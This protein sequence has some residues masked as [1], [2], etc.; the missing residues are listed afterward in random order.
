MEPKVILE[1]PLNIS[2][3]NLVDLS[4]IGSPE[5]FRLVEC[6]ALLSNQDPVLRIVQFDNFK[7]SN[8]PPAAYAAISYIWQG[9]R[10]ESLS[11]TI[12]VEGA[13][14][15][16]PI[17]INIIQQA[18]IACKRR[19]LDYIWLDRLCIMQTDSN[20]KA[21]QIQRMFDIYKTGLPLVL[22]GGL[23]KLV[24]LDEETDWILRAWT[25]QEAIVSEAYVLVSA[26]DLHIP[27]ERPSID[28]IVSDDPRRCMCR[29]ESVVPDMSAFCR[30]VDLLQVIRRGSGKAIC[31]MNATAQPT[32]MHLR[33]F[34]NYQ[35]RRREITAFADATQTIWNGSNWSR[36]SLWQSSFFRTSK[37][38]VDM[39]FSI[40]GLFGVSLN[41]KEFASTDRIRATIVLAQE[42]LK[43]SNKADWLIAGW[44]EPPDRRLS[45]FPELPETSV[46]TVPRF[47]T[48]KDDISDEPDTPPYDIRHRFDSSWVPGGRMDDEGY[49]YFTTKAVRVASHALEIRETSPC[50]N[51]PR[52]TPSGLLRALDG[53]LWEPHTAEALP[54]QR[55]PCHSSQGRELFA[56]VVGLGFG[57]GYTR[58]AKAVLLEEHTPGR[59]HRLPVFFE[60]AQDTPEEW[61]QMDLNMGPVR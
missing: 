48:E 18:C 53:S 24:R 7:F 39:V 59:F 21:W 44:K 47:S 36:H 15:G 8:R 40:M 19:R 14:D 55:G 1:V 57:Q 51:Q 58:H 45:S 41:P 49:F 6:A 30:L 25:L 52:T 35:T 37:R 3:Q 5:K 34:G 43:R 9:N 50:S 60:L 16:D 32:V 56:A 23:M 12:V 61:R 2:Q 29:V 17:S 13:L 33:V 27:P 42:Y 10:T 28:L 22:P 26:E 31:Q 38:P 4:N 20:D 46:S 54:E 11:G